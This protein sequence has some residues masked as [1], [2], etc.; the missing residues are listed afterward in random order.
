M[1]GRGLSDDGAPRAMAN[2]P[3]AKKARKRDGRRAAAK[4]PAML[5][6]LLIFFPQE[7]FAGRRREVVKAGPWL[8]RGCLRLMG[9]ANQ[10]PRSCQ[11]LRQAAAAAPTVSSTKSRRH[12]GWH[13]G[14]RWA[15]QG[16][17]FWLAFARF[18][19]AFGNKQHP[20][21]HGALHMPFGCFSRPRPRTMAGRVS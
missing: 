18:C 10:G 9:S 3:G 6:N 5:K 7:P 20:Q 17:Q 14:Q 11:S 15:I 19:R 12:N 8:A 13:L 4:S 16:Q 1:I 2:E 21:S